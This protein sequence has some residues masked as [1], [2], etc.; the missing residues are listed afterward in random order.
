[1]LH[2][3]NNLSTTICSSMKTML[4]QYCSTID[5]VRTC[6]L[7]WVTMI[8]IVNKHV[9]SILL[10]PVSTTVNNRCCFINAEQYCWNN[11]EQH[12][13]LNNIVHPWKQCCY[14]VVQLSILLQLVKK[15]CWTK[16]ITIIIIIAFSCSNNNREQP[17]LHALSMLN[18]MFMAVTLFVQQ[19]CLAMITVTTI[20]QPTIL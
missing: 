20:V 18:K 16:M 9:L 7:G 11:N 1:M 2:P 6:Q 14:S 19:H 13:S 15:L 17:L 8:T 12:C 10:F 5:T 4:L 3:V